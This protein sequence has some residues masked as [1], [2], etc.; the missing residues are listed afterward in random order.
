[1]ANAWLQRAKRIL[2]EQSDT[3]EHTVLL[4]R[5]A[6]VA[7]GSGA[8]EL[9]LEKA[10]HTLE[11]GRRLRHPDIEAEALQCKARVLIS[12]GKTAE[13][14]ALFDEAMLLAAEGRLGTFVVGKIYCSLISAC[15]QLGE[16]RARRGMDGGW[17][18]MGA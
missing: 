3:P 17:Q 10:G 2:E 7:N 13:G 16:L 8:L 1:M 9:A 5:E 6:E 11:I 15:D 12:L 18:R 4:E 14:F